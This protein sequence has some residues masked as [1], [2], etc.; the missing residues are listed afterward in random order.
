MYLIYKCIYKE[1]RLQYL[2]K[3]KKWFI[4]LDNKKKS[5]LIICVIVGIIAIIA[6][7][8]LSGIQSYEPLYVGLSP[9]EAGEIFQELKDRGISVKTEG[10]GTLLVPKGMANELAMEMAVLGHSAT[11]LNYDIYMN[12]IGIGVSEYDKENYLRFQL[13]ERLQDTIQTMDMINRAIV[14]LNVPEE[15]VFVLD[16][17]KA[18][19]SASV[20]IDLRYSATLTKNQIKGIEEL[21]SKSIAG[22]DVKNITIVDQNMN[23]LSSAF[24]DEESGITNRRVEYENEL[25]KKLENNISSL[26]N[27]VYGEEN[28]TIGVNIVVDFDKKNIEVVEFTPV[29]DDKGI[30]KDYQE[31]QEVVNS[32]EEGD[33]EDNVPG[34]SAND[35]TGSSYTLSQEAIDNGEYYNGSKQVSYLVNEMH[36]QIEKA[37]GDI[38]E[39]SVSI[40]IDEAVRGQSDTSTVKELV[41]KAMGIETDMIIVEFMIFKEKVTAK[42]PTFS[43]NQPVWRKYLQIILLGLAIFVIVTLLALMFI[44]K[45]KQ[46]KR[47][48]AKL[49]AQTVQHQ[50]EK[51]DIAKEY[52]DKRLEDLQVS[53]G[54]DKWEAFESVSEENPEIVVRALRTWMRR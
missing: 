20:M 45:R 53:A 14:T 30:V 50:K 9:E 4:S 38:V 8:S 40:I 51:D 47:I 46:Q 23:L 6:L 37:Q 43:V 3:I 44:S 41:A 49:K 33:G 26:L 32:N 16:D 39:L 42:V 31:L 21:V 27:P 12:N 35:T 7:N 1:T 17:Q 34:V 24:D 48:N 2:S 10:T 19:P 28:F 11:S 13:E 22:L 25:Q 15:N 18:E 54:R 52:E 36:T 29:I 5:T